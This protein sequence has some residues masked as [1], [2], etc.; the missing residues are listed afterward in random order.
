MLDFA[1]SHISDKDFSLFQKLIFKH[2]G[3]HLAEIKKSMLCG[4][5]SKRLRSLNINDYQTYYEL[6]T[7]GHAQ[8]ELET[9]INLITTN[10]TYFF[11]EP[12][13]FDFLQ[14]KILPTYQGHSL[15]VWSAACSSGEEVYTLALVLAES[16][17]VEKD[18][19]ILGSDISTQ[20]LQKAAH[21]IYT[22]D[23]SEKI[24]KVMI[25]KHCLKGKD[26]NVGRFTVTPA[27]RRH[28]RFAQ[29]NLN[30][31][32]PDT[33]MFDI[34]FLRNV[35]IY[36]QAETK[37]AVVGRIVEK[38]NPGG[39]LFIGHSE[40]LSGVSRQLEQIQPTVYRKTR[41]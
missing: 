26:E 39:W 4:R 7:S 3:I 15:R 14:Q 33:G 34:V 2:T 29:I 18:W 35:M 10:E 13:H 32:L 22:M 25:Y 8:G 9:C 21:G 16:L 12:K 27:V 38:M 24:P 37:A 11:R 36:F 30:Q 40:T 23:R 31:Q 1:G 28:V 20:V 19:D 5:L 17:G 41:T 6:L